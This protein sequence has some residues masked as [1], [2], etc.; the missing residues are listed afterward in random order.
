MMPAMTHSTSLESFSNGGISYIDWE[1]MDDGKARS[2]K[3]PISMHQE[4]YF[5]RFPKIEAT[6]TCFSLCW[7]ALPRTLE[8]RARLKA[9]LIGGI[10]SARLPFLSAFLDS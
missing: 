10:F 4:S 3:I 7:I 6:Q 1:A 5:T 9:S 8:L 2:W